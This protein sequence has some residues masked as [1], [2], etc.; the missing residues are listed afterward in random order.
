M[1]YVLVNRVFVRD[2]P[3]NL[4]GHRPV[5]SELNL[6]PQRQYTNNNTDNTSHD[7]ILW[8]HRLRESH[9][10]M[11][12]SNLDRIIKDLPYCNALECSDLSCG[13]MTHQQEMTASVML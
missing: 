8:P 4:S 13:D 7:Y 3:L 6:T 12:R 9:K 5:V 1:K 11:Y 10:N 2:C